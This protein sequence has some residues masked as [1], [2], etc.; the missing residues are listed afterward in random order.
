MSESKSFS[1]AY[2]ESPNRFAKEKFCAVIENVG[3]GG[4]TIENIVAELRERANGLSQIEAGRLKNMA[5]RTLD[6]L[7][8]INLVMPLT[9][10]AGIYKPDQN[11]TAVGTNE[12]LAA[13]G[14]TEEV[15]EISLRQVVAHE[16]YHKAHKHGTRTQINK[17]LMGK[18]TKNGE[19]AVASPGGINISDIDADEVV[20]VWET[21]NVPA[22]RD[23][24]EKVEHAIRISGISRAAFCTA[25][26]ARNMT[27][28]TD[29][30]QTIA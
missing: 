26:N 5:D 1:S 17:H 27:Q 24:V 11:I 22:Y 8:D 21:G 3:D 10:A 4:E 6:V 28:L 18:T 2:A 13:Y 19:K 7:G 30:T 25:V 29:N 12:L 15:S 9:G 20:T 16:N 14:D 23:R